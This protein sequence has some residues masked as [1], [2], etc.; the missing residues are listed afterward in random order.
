MPI[1]EVIKFPVGRLRFTDFFH[2]SLMRG[3]R[4]ITPGKTSQYYIALG[5]F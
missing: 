4:G 2:V 3:S 1:G 5:E